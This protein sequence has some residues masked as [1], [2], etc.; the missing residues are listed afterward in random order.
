MVFHGSGSWRP[1]DIDV[2]GDRDV[3]NIKVFTIYGYT[4]LFYEESEK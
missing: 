3:R 1:E 2:L 4:Q